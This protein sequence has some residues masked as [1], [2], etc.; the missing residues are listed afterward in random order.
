MVLP[1]TCQTFLLLQPRPPTDFPS[2]GQASLPGAV[3]VAGQDVDL[4]WIG[5][6]GVRVSHASSTFLLLRWPGAWV[7]WGV[8][9]PAVYVT[10]E[11]RHAY[12]VRLEASGGPG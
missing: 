12:Q 6:K 1:S 8:A 3:L 7:L 10:L 5:A 4:P 11:P 2:H 9:D